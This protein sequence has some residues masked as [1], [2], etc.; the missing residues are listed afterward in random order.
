MLITASWPQADAAAPYPHTL[1][2]A[3]PMRGVT[4]VLSYQHEAEGARDH[5][6]VACTALV[7]RCEHGNA[8]GGVA[9]LL[10]ELIRHGAAFSTS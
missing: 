9:V 8:H 3:R 1:H 10:S 2:E 6:D 7:Q 4:F 5:I